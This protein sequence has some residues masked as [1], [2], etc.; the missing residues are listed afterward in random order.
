MVEVL[1]SCRLRPGMVF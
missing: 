1:G